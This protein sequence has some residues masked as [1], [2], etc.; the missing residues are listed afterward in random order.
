M[1]R[2]GEWFPVNNTTPEMLFYFSIVSIVLTIIIIANPAQ[3]QLRNVS[4]ERSIGSKKL[5]TQ[6]LVYGLICLKLHPI[7]YPRR[8]KDSV[9]RGRGPEAVP[10]AEASFLCS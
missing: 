10:E 7:S 1:G 8:K 2:T 9:A 6:V 5:S 3:F 4:S